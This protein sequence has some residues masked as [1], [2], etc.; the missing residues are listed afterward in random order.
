MKRG[1]LSELGGCLMLLGALGLALLMGWAMQA[2]P[3]Q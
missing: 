1:L 2:C 3:I